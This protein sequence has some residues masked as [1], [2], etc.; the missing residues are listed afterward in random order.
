MDI[1]TFSM[2]LHILFIL[3]FS[4]ILVHCQ[5]NILFLAADDMRPNLGVYKDSNSDIFKQPPMYTPNLDALA[6]KS[7]LFEKAYDAQALCS[8]SR[9]ATMTSRR[10]DTTSILKIGDY[11]RDYGGNFTTIPQFFKENGYFTIGAGKVFH[12]G[13][14]S[15]PANDHK[16]SHDCK[17]SWSQGCPYHNAPDRYPESGDVSWRGY[18]KSTLDEVPLQDQANVKWIVPKL[19]DAAKAF[20][21]DGTPFFVAFGAYKPHTPWLVFYMIELTNLQILSIAH[22]FDF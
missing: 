13:P 22:L 5:K 18:N 6:S 16:S 9:T 19:R 4:S 7:L 17:Y 11:W 8:P 14:S 15:S 2:L 10:P 21:E 20:K 3:T 1:E 12:G